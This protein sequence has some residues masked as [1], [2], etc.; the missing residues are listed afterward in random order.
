MSIDLSPP[1]HT[2]DQAQPVGKVRTRRPWTF[3]ALA[4]FF[5]VYLAFLYGPMICMFVLSFQGPQGALSFPMRGV[6][7]YWFTQLFDG[8]GA[9]LGGALSRSL[10]LAVMVMAITVVVSVAAGMAFRRRFFGSSAI[11]YALI[12]SLTAP[13]YLLGI[14]IGLMFNLLGWQPDW[15]SSALGAQ[16]TWTLPFGILITFAIF[17]R[18]NPSLEEASRDLG[19]NDWQTLR[20]V[21]LPILLPGLIAIALF[22]FTLSYD[23]FARTLQTTGQ[24]NT[25]PIEIWSMTQNVT[26]P[27]IYAL[28]TLTT[29]LSF[30]VIGIALGSIVLIQRRRAKR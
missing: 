2:P 27:S 30:L 20:M 25:V 18:F 8:G 13:G 10:P 24:S 19:A 7:L 9:D 14:G 29:A 11:F 22:G 3:Y 21:V 23:E 17:G 28:G 4:L 6:S 26:S 5:V 12:V 16:L 1:A 15:Y